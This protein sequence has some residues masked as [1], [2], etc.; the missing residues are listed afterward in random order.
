MKLH[1]GCGK[2]YFAG[3]TNLDI[4]GT[5]ADIIDDAKTLTSIPNHSCDIIYAAHLLE[6]FGRKEVAGVL[7]VWFNKLKPKGV[8]RLSVPDFEKVVY[9]YHKGYKMPQLWGF[10]IGGQRD[11]FDYHKI[12]FDRESLT[13]LLLETG[14]KTVK[15]WDWRKTEHSHYDDYSQAYLPHMDKEKGTLM[16]LNLEAYI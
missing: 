4:E 11:E 15:T 2:K 16:S 13:D 5:T 3:W 12:V 7:K 1:L 14:F 8:L 6:H 10:L 9:M